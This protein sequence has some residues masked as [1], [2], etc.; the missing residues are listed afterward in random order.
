MT[1]VLLPFTTLLGA[2]IGS[3]LNVVIHRVPAGLSV[4]S[5]PSACPGCG[6]RIRPWDNVP[7]L[8]WLVLRGRCRD[9]AEPISKRYPLVEALTAA[10]FAAVTVR[11]GGGELTDLWALPA[12]LLLTALGV[13]LSGIDL[14]THRLPNPLV[15]TGY[16]AGGPLLVAASLLGAGDGT[17]ALV[18]AGIGAAAMFGLHFAAMVAYPGGMG[19]GDV[20][21]AGVTG[22]YLAWLGWGPLAVGVMASFVIGAVVGLA[23]GKGRRGQGIPFGPFMFTGVAVGVAVGE[24]L[25]AAYLGL[26]AP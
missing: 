17:D 16:L 24:P 8:S 3:F 9:C 7:V 12:F 15:F 25:W 2:L 19:F 18:R 11:F 23:L 20:K 1:V 13:A 4:V 26:M 10:L 5:P 6:T 22:M 21:L 14:D